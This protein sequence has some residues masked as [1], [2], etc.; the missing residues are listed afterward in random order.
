MVGLAVT[1]NLY[2]PAANVFFMYAVFV[3]PTGA[4]T[5][6]TLLSRFWPTVS[7]TILGPSLAVDR[8]LALVAIAYGVLVAAKARHKMTAPTAANTNT[9]T[10]NWLRLNR[11]AIGNF[12]DV[13]LF[14]E[15]R[16]AFAIE[17]PF[18]FNPSLANR[19]R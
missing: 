13:F 17:I 3:V 14:L 9:N 15:V 8:L 19:L 7:L 2:T 1:Q 6:T 12:R 10:S 18:R 5:Y 4:C 11:E 16:F